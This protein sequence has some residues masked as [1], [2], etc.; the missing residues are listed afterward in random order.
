MR[1]RVAR[2]GPEAL[3]VLGQEIAAAKADDPLAPVT[4]VVDRRAVG[5]AIRRALAGGGTALGS[6][7]TGG[8]L[9]RRGIVNVRFVTLADLA[10]L[11][12][13]GAVAASGRRPVDRTVILA[14]ARRVLADAP[15]PLFA[16]V[17]DHPATVRALASTYEEL[18]LVTP[19]AQARL[20]EQSPQAGEVVALVEAMGERLAGWY[21]E[22]DLIDSAVAALAPGA[23]A[24]LEPTGPVLLYL[25][26]AFPPHHERLV[27]ALARRVTVTAVLGVTGVAEA[28]RSAAEL[29]ERLGGGPVE[30]VLPVGGPSGT[31]VVS[32]PAADTE[33]L[34]AVRSLLARHRAGV[35][36][37]RMAIVHGAGPYPR[38]V[39]ESLRRAGI[40]FNGNGLRALSSTVPG[41]V[42]LGLFE[43]VD[44]DWRRE[45]V[46]AWLASGPLL[47]AGRPVPAS[48]WDLASRRAGVLGG[49]DG[50]S[51]GLSDL[52]D[53][54]DD[55]ASAAADG[56]DAARREA[57]TARRL[58]E[59]VTDLAG[60][61]ERTPA[62]WSGWRHWAT[63]LVADLLGG[64]TRRT[65]WPADEE[66]ALTEIEEIL[67]RLPELEAVAPRPDL[68]TFRAVVTAALESAAP[69]VTRFG[70]GVLVG[71][72]HQV[73]GLDLD[74]VFFVGMAEGQFPVR[75]GDD[76][77]L[78]DREREGTDGQV[79]LRS[80]SP[81]DVERDYLAALSA[82]PE[83]ILSFAR[84]DQRNGRE[85]RPARGVL[86][87]LGRLEGA[88][89][90]LYPRDVDRLGPLAGFDVVP[91]DLA[92][93][94]SGGEPTS[95]ADRDRRALVRWWAAGQPLERHYLASLDPVLGRG[96]R[97]RAGRRRPGFSRFDGR[98]GAGV[99]PTPASG[100]PR[101]PTGL[102]RYATCPRRYLLHTVLGVRVR[103]RPEDI[104][105]LSPLDR[106]TAMHRILE[107]FF[108]AEVDL[109][110]AERI[111]PDAGWE[112]EDEKR[113]LASADEVFDDLEARGLTGR[114]LF[115][116]I[117]RA[118]IVRDLRAFLRDDADYRASRRA[119]PEAV[120]LVFGSDGRPP[121]VVE[122]DD[123]RR[124]AFRGQADRVD[125]STDGA[126]T[127]LDYKT[128]SGH[129]F[130]DIA[131]DPVVR[132]TKLQLPVY[133]LAAQ[134]QFGPGAVRAAYWF[135]SG[136]HEDP[137]IE[138]PLDAER[139]ERF[140]TAV[141]VIVDGIEAGAFPANPG[142]GSTNCTYC[143]FAAVCPTN[144]VDEWDRVR[145]DPALA[146]YQALAEPGDTPPGSGVDGAGVDGA[147]VDRSGVDRLGLDGAAA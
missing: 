91:S 34:V 126:L 56:A 12:G 109:P 116:R 131:V 63:S 25:P 16:G 118:A 130:A 14:A 3:A 84:G 32:A 48:A 100:D 66:Q 119:V 104:L 53:R 99:I 117:D 76:V 47:H 90:T 18:R 146:G 95:L 30:G 60:R 50:W 101:S 87:T 82:A 7:D 114:R 64:P 77:L 106:G 54:L 19:S 2:F 22:V 137:R 143:E 46:M 65:G 23:D 70:V 62:S 98:V 132:G 33:V 58:A 122:L 75:V 24:V 55:I 138:Y 49:L 57:R 83:R 36:L 45:E 140:R 107:E 10:A 79:P 120:E 4:V 20:G 15:G 144:R 124:V 92:A 94:A 51:T 147:G 128:G 73:I 111:R 141:E 85:Q 139:T 102:E 145:R 74:V 89:R 59:M 61:F 1:G 136:R 134:Q 129:G 121:V 29:L 88:G 6:P 39:Q 44:H 69:Q 86:D 113:L 80:P 127:V 9:P 81:G 125:R 123:G 72:V 38:L 41:R 52:A 96:L 35:P 42:L 142:P 67:R 5:L 103:E 31:A 71:G 13:G 17:P 78:P 40:P 43:L 135:V 97:T 108:A 133:A 8:G 105:R 115:W 28:D 27:R 93:V 68:S 110:S 11:L 21:D 112:P 26:R 37:D